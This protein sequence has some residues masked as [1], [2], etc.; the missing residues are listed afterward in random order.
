MESTSPGV[1]GIRSRRGVLAVD[2]VVLCAGA[3]VAHRIVANE[4][5]ARA[6]AVR[7]VFFFIISLLNDL[8]SFTPGFS[9]GSD[10]FHM[11]ETVSTVLALPFVANSETVKTVAAKR[12]VSDHRLKPG[13]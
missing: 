11:S 5:A 8:V 10:Y 12:G 13:E 1:N 2:A 3:V 4:I 9:P 6:I 7:A